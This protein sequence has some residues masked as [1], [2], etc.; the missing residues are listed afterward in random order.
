M[1]VNP[2][3][4]DAGAVQIKVDAPKRRAERVG[5]PRLALVVERVRLSKDVRRGVGVEPFDRVVL[6]HMAVDRAHRYGVVHQL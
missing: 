1:H 4:S 2:L 6:G 3:D 5:Q